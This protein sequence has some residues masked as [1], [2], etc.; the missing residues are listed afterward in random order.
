MN[1][2]QQQQRQP[3]SSSVTREITPPPRRNVPVRNDSAATHS[4]GAYTPTSI[5]TPYLDDSFIDQ[6]RNQRPPTTSP[7]GSWDAGA[8]LYDSFATQ[9][10]QPSANNRSTTNPY[11]PAAPPEAAAVRE[12]ARLSRPAVTSI[13]AGGLERPKKASRGVAFA[14]E[15]LLAAQRFKQP[16]SPLNP[17]LELNPVSPRPAF[18]DRTDT[19]ETLASLS[20]PSPGLLR[21]GTTRKGT[22]RTRKTVKLPSSGNFTIKGHLPESLLSSVAY[23]KGEEYETVNYTAV[24]CDP[25]DFVR[26]GYTLRTAHDYNRQTEIAIVVTMYNEGIEELNR[27]LFGIFQNIQHFCQKKGKYGWDVDGWKKIV[28]VLVSDGR[29]K[30][31]PNVLLALQTMGA[32]LPG[33]DQHSVNGVPTT[34]HIYESTP[35]LVLDDRLQ[36]WSTHNGIPPVQFIF[37]LKEKNLKKINSHRW[38]F[39]AVCPIIQPKVCLLVDV[40]T[41]P[42][43]DSIWKLWKAFERD[44]HCAGACGEIRVGM[45]WRGVLNPLVASQN[46][47]YKISNHLDKALES[48]FGYIGVLPG[49]FSAYRYKALLDNMPNRGPLAS[50]FKG[51]VRPGSNIIP[52]IFLSTLYLAE[53]R[54]L[55]LELVVKPQ[56]RWTLKYVAKSAAETDVPDS[57]PEF[58]AQRRRWLNGSFFAQLYAL[59]NIPRTLSTNH[60]VLR[61]TV[62]MLQSV[63]SSISLLFNWFGPSQ[64]AIIFYFLFSAD[65]LK[66]I[67]PAY[68]AQVFFLIYPTLLCLLFIASLGNRPQASK[69]IYKAS[70]VFFSFIGLA[71]LVLLVYKIVEIVRENKGLGSPTEVGSGMSYVVGLS[72]TYGTYL[73]GSVLQGDAWHMVTS[74]FQYLLLL[75]SYINVLQI[76][77]LCNLHDVSWGTKGD[78]EGTALP[79][80]QTGKN[81]DGK[82]VAE[83]HVADRGE[84]ESVWR[85]GIEDIKRLHEV[86]D[87]KVVDPRVALEDAYKSFRTNLLLSWLASNIILFG[88]VTQTTPRIQSMYIVY[89]LYFT[90]GLSAFR[91][92]GV[93]IYK[94]IIISYNLCSGHGRKGGNKSNRTSVRPPST[95]APGHTVVGNKWNGFVVIK[96]EDG[97]DRAKVFLDA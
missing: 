71:I 23:S 15:T 19:S 58:I 96:D 46:F 75:P 52:G 60:S 85:E 88:I 16:L 21:H 59:V 51:E 48:V 95:V 55:A 93:L 31:H 10:W 30:I 2:L 27:T 92:L 34:A 87:V 80:V 3:R 73:L 24:T 1:H 77:A 97:I 33:I 26:E 47:E 67:I 64:F 49:A 66:T 70:M 69:T 61:K 11:F 42:L 84:L 63:Y 78:N 35:Q 54:V 89:L 56:S 86:K 44:P 68:I 43:K 12:P 17:D 22:V 37:C 32:Y 53:D 39:N 8:D 83:V 76:Y 81:Q 45:N 62:F 82:S 38:F 40:G 50:Y 29:N 79:T 6:Q 13:L 36:V 72:A 41:R 9:D 20:T 18:N 91:L 74:M 90:A 25:D 57:V 4:T 94:A 14:G 7:P 28:I 65:Q 5:I